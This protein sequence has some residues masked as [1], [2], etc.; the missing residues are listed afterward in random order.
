MRSSIVTAE[1][2]CLPAC[3]RSRK[4]IRV[5]QKAARIGTLEQ[6]GH[7]I[8]TA[9]GTVAVVEDQID[10]LRERILRPDVPFADDSLKRQCRV[11]GR[12]SESRSFGISYYSM[13]ARPMSEVN[14]EALDFRVASESL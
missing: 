13:D 4:A 12:G 5:A 6:V 7:V 2:S 10:E 14:S 11:R 8:R 3:V 1:R 9:P